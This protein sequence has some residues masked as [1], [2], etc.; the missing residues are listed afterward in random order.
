MQSM[1]NVM[2]K[3]GMVGITGFRIVKFF[4]DKHESWCF[5]VIFSTGA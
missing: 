3:A 1:T 4:E 5:A 2:L